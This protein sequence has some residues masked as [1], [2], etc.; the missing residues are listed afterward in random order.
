LTDY[1]KPKFIVVKELQPKDEMLKRIRQGHLAI[2]IITWTLKQ[3]PN[4]MDTNEGFQFNIRARILRYLY[5]MEEVTKDEIK[6]R[7]E[8]IKSDRY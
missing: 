2:G 5:N 6:K 1:H 7:E 8:L 3:W 4:E